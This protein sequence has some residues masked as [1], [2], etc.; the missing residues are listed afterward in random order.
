MTAASPGIIT[1]TMKN[2]HY[3]AYE[4]YV[5]AAA[6]EMRKEYELIVSKGL[7]LQLD[8]PDLAMER[9]I[10]YQDDPVEVFQEVVELHIEAINRA[11]VNIPRDRVRL[12]V[13]WGN[14]EGPH[15]L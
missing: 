15:H 14:S 10:T 11:L 13:C 6:E 7:V 3:P 1:L 2:A 9:H 8:C 4:D 12:H 5:F